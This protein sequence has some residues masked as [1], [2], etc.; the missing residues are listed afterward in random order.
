MEP[1]HMG[2]MHGTDAPAVFNETL[3]EV[4]EIALLLPASRAEALVAL[5]RRRRQSVGQILR[6]LIDG[7]LAGDDN[8]SAL[9]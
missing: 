5:S 7:A 8:A 6:Q 3:G 2:T 4:V 1:S 9:L